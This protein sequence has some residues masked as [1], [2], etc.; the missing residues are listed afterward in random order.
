MIWASWIILGRIIGFHSLLAIAGTIFLLL[1]SPPLAHL[2]NLLNKSLAVRRAVALAFLF[3]FG[4]PP[5]HTHPISLHFSALGWAKSKWTASRRPSVAFSFRPRGN[6]EAL[7]GSAIEAEEAE[8][9]AGNPIYFHFEVHENQRWWMGLDWTS[10]LLPQERPSWCDSHLLPVSPPPSFTLPA[11]A[12]IILPAP[13]KQDPHARVKRTATWRWL[14][15]DWS[16]VRAGSSAP[17]LSVAATSPEPENEGFSLGHQSNRSLS[18]ATGLGGSPPKPSQ[19]VFD[20]TI[21]PTVRAQSI[22]E[23][24]FSKGLERLKGRTT[25][26]VVTQAKTVTASPARTSGEFKRGRAGSQA[27]EDLRAFEVAAV[28]AS[29]ETSVEKDDVSRSRALESTCILADNS[30]V[31]VTDADGW[32][33]GDNKWESMGARGGL[34]KVRLSARWASHPDSQQFTRRRRWQRRAVCTE[35]V[36][37]I[38]SE[39]KDAPPSPN[40]LKAPPTVA[41]VSEVKVEPII[42]EKNGAR[43]PEGMIIPPGSPVTRDDQLRLRLKKTMGSVGG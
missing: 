20:D 42:E 34:G 4:S 37:R 29:V 35:T 27:S 19:S 15:D 1:P 31:K 5:D 24:A 12:S 30:C 26:P 11:A 40:A 17:A 28:V 36:Q 10:A 23:H 6:Q 21:S 41:T 9:K 7:H 32:V 43:E 2:I 18:I 22:A 39:S 8:E 25:S 33:Y 13:T 3:T 16:V 14:D 38:P